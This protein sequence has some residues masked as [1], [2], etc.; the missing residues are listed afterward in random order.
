MSGS[1]PKN[2]SGP[3]V[4]QPWLVFTR[5]PPVPDFPGPLFWHI[6]HISL[7]PAENSMS[8]LYFLTSSSSLKASFMNQSSSCAKSAWFHRV[9]P[10]NRVPQKKTMN[11]QFVI[12]WSSIVFFMVRVKIGSPFQWYFKG[13]FVSKMTIATNFCP[14]GSKSWLTQ[15]CLMLQVER[16]NLWVLAPS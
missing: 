5:I 14:Q 15:S 12:S 11:Y 7:F 9:P 10:E 6:W 4:S 2:G 13:I 3:H 8:F 16:Q 1:V